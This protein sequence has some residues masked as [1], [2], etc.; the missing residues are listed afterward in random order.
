MSK[1]KKYTLFADKSKPCAFF[2]TA[3]GCR[4]GDR[5]QF[6]HLSAA[7]IAALERQQAMKE[8]PAVIL[9][10]P[11]VEPRESATNPKGSKAKVRKA[12]VGVSPGKPPKASKTSKKQTVPSVV[13]QSV[14]QQAPILQTSA[15]P[16][17]E[18]AAFG[19]PGPPPVSPIAS[20]SPDPSAK[21][22]K[23]KHL[24]KREREMKRAAAA[25]AT[26]GLQPTGIIASRVL[27]Y[28]PRCGD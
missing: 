10:C 21:K 9:S 13:Q 6:K 25:Q 20:L 15:Q 4:N 2:L 23:K 8:E 26:P 7:A 22:K 19:L 5:C 27:A 17:P 16:I 14:P 24:G 28:I 3:E 11:V 18:S 1:G 12:E